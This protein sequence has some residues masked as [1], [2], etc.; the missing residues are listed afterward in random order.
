MWTITTNNSML[1]SFFKEHSY[2]SAEILINLLD[3]G[4]KSFLPNS[5]KMLYIFRKV[6]WLL[7][8]HDSFL[9]HNPINWIDPFKLTMMLI[10]FTILMYLTYPS[11]TKCTYICVCRSNRVL[12][13]WRHKKLFL[14][15][16]FLNTIYIGRAW[17]KTH[18][19]QIWWKS[20]D[21][22]PRYGC[23]NT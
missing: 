21:W 9:P 2:H 10:Y 19:A 17:W 7:L 15:F 5:W 4:S 13:W 16:R 23:M 6:L 18:T 11:S 20:V 8:W 22:G 14:H 3:K 1:D 12:K